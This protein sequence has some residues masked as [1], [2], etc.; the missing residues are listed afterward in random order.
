MPELL[1][2][3]GAGINLIQTYGMDQGHGEITSESS[4]GRIVRLNGSPVA[5]T[6]YLR[7]TSPGPYF[8]SR[9]LAKT[10]SDASGHW[11]FT[12]LNR[13]HLY[14]VD[15]IDPTGVAHPAALDRLSPWLP[16]F[17]PADGGG[18]GGG[19]PWAPDPSGLTYWYDAADDA[20]LTYDGVTGVVSEWACKASTSGQNVLTPWNDPLN[21]GDALVVSGAL[22]QAVEFG[23][24]GDPS[25]LRA[26][27]FKAIGLGDIDCLT[28]VVAEDGT[29]MSAGESHVM[30]SFDGFRNAYGLGREHQF[31]SFKDGANAGADSNDLD[32]RISTSQTFTE[33]AAK[34][35]GALV[36]PRVG[37][38]VCGERGLNLARL[39]QN[40]TQVAANESV[41]GGIGYQLRA[42][43]GGYIEAPDDGTHEQG[44][45]GKIYEVIMIHN[46]DTAVRQKIEG[47]LAHKWGLEGSLPAD[48]PYKAAAPTT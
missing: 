8:F 27:T 23:N 1:D 15:V 33:F 2:M 39:Y 13:N 44:F 4:S 19:A 29:P 41:T 48:H 17:P 30:A 37:T 47:Y 40:G 14:R 22:G 10:H 16:G 25:I 18:G 11:A 20:S 9:T 7:R 31:I 45:T 21:T 26:V 46:R 42:V 36:T 32:Y 28:F 3:D 35:E 5:T 6:V 34:A 43:L 12:G 38:M 24:G